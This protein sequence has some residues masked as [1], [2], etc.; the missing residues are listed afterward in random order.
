MSGII[1]AKYNSID[2]YSNLQ[3]CVTAVSCYYSRPSPS[4][5]SSNRPGRV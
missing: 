4:P 1:L 2:L 5:Y 3:A